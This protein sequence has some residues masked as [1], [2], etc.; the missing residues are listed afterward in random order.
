MKIMSTA[1]TRPR[2]SSGVA[3][4]IKVPRTMTLTMS[5][6]P[7]KT[8]AASESARLCEMPN[9]TVQT[10]NPATHHSMERP[11]LRRSGR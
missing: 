2:I 9:N 4:W 7:T 11:A 10:P 1:L 5:V 6:A 3:T 8:S